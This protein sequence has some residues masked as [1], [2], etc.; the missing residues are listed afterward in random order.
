MEH[1]MVLSVCTERRI[2]RTVRRVASS[3]GCGVCAL[4]SKSGQRLGLALGPS[5]PKRKVS[6]FCPRTSRTNLGSGF[7][8]V[9]ILPE[10]YSTAPR[11]SSG[12]T[13]VP[14]ASPR[15]GPKSTD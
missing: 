1:G 6:S 14:S 3:Q 4:G 5:A 11:S 12:S 13:F 15:I 10:I 9:F 7:I 2:L 8:M